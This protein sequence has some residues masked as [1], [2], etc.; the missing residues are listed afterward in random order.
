MGNEA[1][2]YWKVAGQ[3][4]LDFQE[5]SRLCNQLIDL[6]VE[7]HGPH[8]PPRLYFTDPGYPHMMA[9]HPRQGP[10]VKSGPFFSIVISDYEMTQEEAK[11]IVD[12]FFKPQYE[13][14]EE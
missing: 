8:V 7:E 9:W 12:D 3:E 1:V 11:A 10:V 13:P 4:W 6:W 2:V 14:E 5:V